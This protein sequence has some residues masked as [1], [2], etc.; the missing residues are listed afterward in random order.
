MNATLACI[1]AKANWMPDNVWIT[2]AKLTH[3]CNREQEQERRDK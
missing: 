2:E 1:S 3:D